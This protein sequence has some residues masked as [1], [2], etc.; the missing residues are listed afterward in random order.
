MF[1]RMES[2]FRNGKWLGRWGSQKAAGH[3]RSEEEGTADTKVLRPKQPAGHWDWTLRM[4]KLIGMRLKKQTG[5][6]ILW[7]TWKLK[8]DSL[9]YLLYSKDLPAFWKGQ[10]YKNRNDSPGFQG[11]GEEGWGEGLT[12]KWCKGILMGDENILPLNCGTYTTVYVY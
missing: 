8:H 11:V 5:A 4:G 10:N 9:T 1:W 2:A 3:E 12:T 6:M 7:I